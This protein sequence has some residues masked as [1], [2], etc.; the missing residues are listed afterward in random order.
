[1]FSKLKAVNSIAR[2]VL[3]NL[4]MECVASSV[5]EHIDSLLS[6]DLS[7]LLLLVEGSLLLK[8]SLTHDLGSPANIPELKRVGECLCGLAV[9]EKKGLYSRDIHNDFRC[10][11]PECKEAGFRSFAALPLIC[12]E[13][14]EGVLGIASRHERDFTVHAEFLDMVGTLFAT[15]LK[16][17]RIYEQSRQVASELAERMQE[18]TAKE[19][20]LRKSEEL[21]EKIFQSQKDLIL[22]LEPEAPQK[23]VRCNHAANQILGYPPEEI[24]GR[25][26]DSLCTFVPG[27]I[28]ADRLKP[29]WQD[30]FDVDV[31]AFRRKDRATVYL[32]T[33]SVPLTGNRGECIGYFFVG[34]D[35]TGRLKAERARREEHSF[36]AAVIEHASEGLCVCHAVEEFP[37]VRFTVWNEQMCRITGYTMDDINRIGWYQALY[38]DETTQAVARER[39]ER[40]RQ[41]D[42]LQ[43]EQ[44]EITRADGKKRILSI[45]T[46]T[47]ETSQSGTHTLALLQDLTEQKRA[48][49]L[50]G[51]QRDLAVALAST[52]D[53]EEACDLL[54]KTAVKIDSI[55][56]G[57]VYLVDSESRE[58]SLIS[59]RGLS[60]WF[61]DLVSHYG[62]DSP[63]ARLA[64]S[65]EPVYWSV[66]NGTDDLQD[67]LTREGIRAVAILPVKF[68]GKLTALLN[69]ASHSS[70]D[71]PAGTRSTLEAIAAQIGGVVTRVQ[72]GKALR[73]SEARFRELAECV[74]EI[75]WISTIDKLLYISPAFEEVF[76]AALKDVF[77]HPDF[78]FD[79]IHPEDRDRIRQA[80]EVATAEGA[81]FDEEFRILRPDGSERWLWGRSFPVWEEGLMVRRVGIAEDI[82]QR[83]RAEQQLQKSMNTLRAVFDGISD[84]L[85]LVD[86][87]MR[88][89]MLNKAARGLY[90]V[91]SDASVIGKPCFEAIRSKPGPCAECRI[92]PLVAGGEHASFERKG[93]RGPETIEQVTIFPV[94]EEA[95][96]PAS[97]II[98]IRDITKTKKIEGDLVQADKMISLGILVSGVAH[99]INNPN[100]FIMLNTPILQEAWGSIS[101]ILEKY[102]AENDDFIV[103]GLPYSEMRDEVFKLFSGVVEGSR[104]ISRIV[105]ELK[106]F[107]RHD[108]T[109]MDQPVNVNDVV[110]NACSLGAGMIKGSTDAFS[111]FCDDGLPVVRGSA[112]KLE[113][114]ILN[115]IQNACQALPGRNSAVRIST[116]LDPDSGNVLIE[117]R[118]EGTGIAEDVLPHIMAPFVTTKQNLGGTGLGL[119]VSANIIRDH[120]GTILV[121]SKRGAGTTVTISIPPHKPENGLGP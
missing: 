116:G 89:L 113:Q 9:T 73:E 38:P 120:G 52:G 44:W 26:L 39:M 95:G 75:F 41:G 81:T 16:N 47:L 6:P 103:G 28:E 48:G 61:V 27:E 7:F 65:G 104:R 68:E 36:R 64:M 25:S 106:N 10:T 62:P 37:Y 86:G 24:V 13:D 23:I 63:E 90:E 100:N 118:D 92:A 56:S 21:L 18:L 42:N 17:A 82:T 22:I 43:N 54:L 87:D 55:D 66:P 80:H 108:V 59:H 70:P 109:D 88:L 107:A 53:L 20:E 33:S 79:L 30:P 51:I 74:R 40:M 76:G 19:G 72:A 85:L 102:Y 8:G 12:G 34:K 58:L 67:L 45:S 101:P 98:H 1:M 96:G 35:I 57:G 60:Q 93:F 2:E 32:E 83:K 5:L 110:R 14:V 49:R 97:A 69:L 50:A 112:Q 29:G 115:L 15:G 4:S 11:L 3:S 71:I 105:E 111:I 78:L 84:P 46:S 99:E 121:E 94:K 31:R 114:V 77:S 91:S 119:S 117:V